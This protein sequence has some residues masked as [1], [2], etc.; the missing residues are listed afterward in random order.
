MSMLVCSAFFLLNISN[1]NITLAPVFLHV[2]KPNCVDK[3]KYED[4]ISYPGYL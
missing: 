4:T 1:L 3:G 2:Q